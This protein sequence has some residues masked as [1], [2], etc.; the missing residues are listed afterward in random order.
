MTT[1]EEFEEAIKLVM[2]CTAS[3]SCGCE[4]D[5]LQADW[6]KYKCRSYLK[7]LEERRARELEDQ[8]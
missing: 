2:K 3:V 5:D 7:A 6:L 4:I 1:K 8:L